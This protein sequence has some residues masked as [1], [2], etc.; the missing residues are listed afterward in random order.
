[1]KINYFALGI[2]SC[3][4]LFSCEKEENESSNNSTSTSTCTS[5]TT[6]SYAKDIAPLMSTNCVSCHNSSQSSGGIILDNYASVSQ[7]ASSSLHAIEN[8]SMPPSG[9]LAAEDIQKLTC[10]ISQ[11]KKNN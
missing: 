11:G 4:T 3:F 1:M 9:K 6:I 8:G 2:L 7:F 5:N 10:W